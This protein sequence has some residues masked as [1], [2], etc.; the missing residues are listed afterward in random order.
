[1]ISIDFFK[2]FFN[3]QKKKSDLN[4]IK[5]TLLFTQNQ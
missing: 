5:N 3:L 2:E 4:K 1:M